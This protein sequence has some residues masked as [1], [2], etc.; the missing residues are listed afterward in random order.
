M[1]EGNEGAA[2]FL[3][4]ASQD[5]RVREALNEIM[6]QSRDA[7]RS[8]LETAVELARERGID[9]SVDDLRAEVEKELGLAEIELSGDTTAST[10]K[11]K[12]GCRTPCVYCKPEHE[13]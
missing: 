13:Q 4:M 3:R 12:S 2:S 7:E 11:S 8:V 6:S 9:I 10:C 5:S 1:N